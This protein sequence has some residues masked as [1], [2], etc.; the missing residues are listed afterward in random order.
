MFDVSVARLSSPRR[1]TWSLDITHHPQKEPHSASRSEP[2]RGSSRMVGNYRQT[3][4]EEDC[5][6]LRTMLGMSLREL[7]GGILTLRLVR[8]AE[9]YE[10]SSAG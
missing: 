8:D 3:E 10:D 7:V 2:R 9:Y 1:E 4:F 5:V 6:T